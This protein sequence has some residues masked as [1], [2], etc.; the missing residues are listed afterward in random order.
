MTSPAVGKNFNNWG[1]T[2]STPEVVMN[3][4]LLCPQ[5]LRQ[6]PAQFSWVDQRLARHRFFERAPAPAWALYLFVLTVAD[7]QGLS[8]Y[9]DHTLC[10]RL[11]LSPAELDQARGHLLRLGLI[12]YRAPLTQVLAL[13]RPAPAPIEPAPSGEHASPQGAQALSRSCTRPTDADTAR[14]H[15]RRLHQL[16]T[17]RSRP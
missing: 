13:D 6:R 10:E 11:G 1:A 4:H 7:A 17:T 14:T 12:A 5:R 15:L 16:L 9:A 8:Y 3:K 2:S